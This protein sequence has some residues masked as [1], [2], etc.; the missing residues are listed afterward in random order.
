MYYLTATKGNDK[1]I[2]FFAWHIL[3]EEGR[4]A[5]YLNCTIFTEFKLHFVQTIKIFVYK[6]YSYQPGTVKDIII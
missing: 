1:D 3:G 2:S 4:V 5:M 6:Q